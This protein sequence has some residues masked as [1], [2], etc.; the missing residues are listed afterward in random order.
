[1]PAFIPC[2]CEVEQYLAT[3]NQP[4][5]EDESNR[6]PRPTRNRIRHELLPLLERDYNP[7]LRQ[8]LSDTAE[9]ALAEE[10]YWHGEASPD[11]ATRHLET[12][13]FL[14]AGFHQV[15]LALQRRLLKGFLE[16]ESVAADF[17]HVE[18]LRRC[19]LG[20]S[21][22]VDLPGGWLAVKEGDCLRLRQPEAAEPETLGYQYVLAIPGA[23]RIAE[24][25]A[26][27]SATLLDR[28]SADRAEPGSL[29]RA[30]ALGPELIVR[31][32]H[33][34]DRFRPAY[35]RS[36]EKLKRLFSERRIPP[37][38]R[39][40]WPVAVS[41]TQIVW[42]RGF[43]PSHDHAWIPGSCDAVKIEAVSEK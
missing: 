30:D 8:L 26:T 24:I 13:R 14:L 6:D 5:R 17:H 40:L 7:N 27:I 15:H 1:L 20:E 28:E 36:A 33:P 39:P 22:R 25:A 35:T 38:Q 11:F 9:V 34:G 23:V 3:L 32:W 43:P 12:G 18:S 21:A 31:N 4:W 41:G 37:E 19:A 16:S 2:S 42:V 29:L 10:D